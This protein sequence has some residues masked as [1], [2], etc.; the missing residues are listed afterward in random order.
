MKK[1]CHD[2]QNRIFN[3][4][5]LNGSAIVLYI[6]LSSGSYETVTKFS[7]QSKCDKNIKLLV[8]NQFYKFLK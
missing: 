7:T 2:K 8:I 6:T 3:K 1:L 5:V 4:Q